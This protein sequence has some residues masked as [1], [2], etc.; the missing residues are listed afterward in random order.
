MFKQIA[1]AA[2]LA[3]ASSSA[4]AQQPTPFYVGADYGTTKAD[5]VHH[6][7][8]FGAYAGYNFNANIALEGGFHRLSKS[9]GSYHYDFG[10][11]NSYD[12]SGS[13]KAEQVDLSVIGTLPL[14]KGFSVYGRLGINRL[15]FKTHLTTTLGGVTETESDSESE[16]KVLY[17]V[18]LSYAITPAISARFEI[19]KPHNEFTRAAIGLSYGF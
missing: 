1:I 10:N 16:N 15:Q 6:K 13:G 19:Q 9:A 3:I 17:G 8:G 14:S 18:G 7:H 2:T 4:F 5:G 12:A 11:G